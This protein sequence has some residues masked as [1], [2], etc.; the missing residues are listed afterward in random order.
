MQVQFDD[1]SVNV[2][3]RVI[4]MIRWLL[5]RH[6]RIAVSDRLQIT[7]D[8]AGSTVSAEVRERELVDAAIL[9]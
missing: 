3:E 5:L 6:D 1:L 7:F 4:K 8:C 9:R 2:S